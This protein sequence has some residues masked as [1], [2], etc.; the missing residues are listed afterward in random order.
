MFNGQREVSI[1]E[2][3]SD[4]IELKEIEVG[5]CFSL[6]SVHYMR[7]Q[8]S[9][10]IKP[11]VGHITSIALKTG[12]LFQLPSDTRVLRENLKVVRNDS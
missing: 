12:A 3:D 8:H 5:Q 9:V 4:I 6:Q 1:M 11:K 7:T 2:I 10:C